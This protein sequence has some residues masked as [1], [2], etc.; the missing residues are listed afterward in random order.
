MEQPSYMHPKTTPL[1]SVQPRLAKRLA[2]QKAG[3]PIYQSKPSNFFF[4]LQQENSASD[5]SHLPSQIKLIELTSCPG[6]SPNS[7]PMFGCCCVMEA[8]PGLGHSTGQSH[9]LHSTTAGAGQSQHRCQNKASVIPY[10]ATPHRTL[11]VWAGDRASCF[12]PGRLCSISQQVA[13][14]CTAAI[15]TGISAF[16]LPFYLLS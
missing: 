6:F 9:H 3:T 5:I 8:H 2:G 12:S 7:T 10:H 4:P 16:L 1:Y 11:K 14:N 15:Y 13:S